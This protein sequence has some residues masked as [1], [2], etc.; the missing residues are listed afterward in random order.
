MLAQKN[1]S[2]SPTKSNASTPKGQVLPRIKSKTMLN[3]SSLSKLI[4]TSPKISKVQ[5]LHIQIPTGSLQ[6]KNIAEENS[7]QNH[8]PSTDS[9]IDFHSH[10]NP[11]AKPQKLPPML[12]LQGVSKFAPK[13]SMQDPTGKS[14]LLVESPALLMHKRRSTRKDLTQLQ[15]LDFSKPKE[16]GFSYDS[17]GL[18]LGKS[19]TLSSGKFLFC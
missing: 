5:N 2:G 6:A 4:L 9:P 17:P 14:P 8:L 12:N 13:L 10:F 3:S 16:P 1:N 18:K 7:S 15:R 11:R 19:P